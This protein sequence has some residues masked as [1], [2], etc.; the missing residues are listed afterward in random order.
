VALLHEGGPTLF[1]QFLGNALVAELFMTL[2]RQIAVVCRRP[3]GL[4]LQRE[5]DS[6]LT[7]R[8]GFNFL[9]SNKKMSIYI[10]ATV[11]F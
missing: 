5:L 6:Y 11:D 7:L 8:R 4:D 9:A 2:A 10:F 3:L 1:G